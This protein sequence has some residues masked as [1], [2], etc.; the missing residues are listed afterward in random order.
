VFLDVIVNDLCDN[1][2]C[3]SLQQIHFE[4][5][6]I[7]VVEDGNDGIALTMLVLL[8]KISFVKNCNLGIRSS[9]VTE[10]PAAL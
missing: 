1:I 9:T 5:F 7:R 2:A 8:R 6:L 10:T 3:Q 4:E